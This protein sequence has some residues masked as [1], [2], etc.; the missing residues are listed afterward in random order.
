[1]DASYV[2]LYEALSDLGIR[3]TQAEPLARHA[4]FRI[5]GTAPVAVF[6][7][8]EQQLI[9]AIGCLR[10]HGARY[11][12]LGRTTNVLFADGD[13]HGVA[14]FTTAMRQC[15][16]EGNRITAAAGVSLAQLATEAQRRGLA[17]AE[18]AHGIPGTLGGAVVMNA[19]AYDGAMEQ[20]VVSSRYWLPSTGEIV[21]L[22]GEAH[23]FGYRE[24]IYTAHPEYVLLEA[25]VELTPDDPTAIRT[26]MEAL[27]AR[28]RASQPLELP[29]GGSVFKRPTGHFAGKLIED[30]GLKGYR[31]GDAE[32][33]TKHAGFIVNRGNA[34]AMDVLALIR[35]M[36]ESV[37]QRFGIA[38]ECE[39]R[40]VDASSYHT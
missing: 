27:S 1:M 10:R 4:G 39:I 33:S 9:D 40:Y 5:G 3:T 23:A 6:P 30:C 15:R 21:T 31:I 36:Q 22:S 34:T 26:R 18:F 2:L 17:G 29:S 38:L 24:S 35:H 8:N 32:V 25:T 14:I 13:D 16:V 11:L 12:V 37:L 7:E 28:R 19:G 20:I